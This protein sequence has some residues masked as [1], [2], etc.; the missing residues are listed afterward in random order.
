MYKERASNGDILW[1]CQCSCGN[2]IQIRTGNLIN[3][4]T[5]GKCFHGKDI[6]GQ[7]FGKLVALNYDH[8]SPSKKSIWKCQC[9]C[10]S[11]SFVNITDLIY[12]KTQSCGCTKS[13]GEEKIAQILQNNGL[14]FEKQKTFPD[15]IFEDSNY[16][17][18]FDFWV[19]NSYI[20]EYDGIQH[21]EATGGWNTIDQVKDT[22]KR[23]KYKNQWCLKHNIPI[24]RIPYTSLEKITLE[25]LKPSSSK[26]IVDDG[27]A[28]WEN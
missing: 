15:C 9:D 22:Q 26:F 23:D 11:I 3:Q 17:A 14:S 16:P 28:A 10:G 19:E 27:A 7:R 12:G 4:K 24:I 18:L 6:S 5:C 8:T 13:R 1:N 21:F 2:I 20:V 25:D